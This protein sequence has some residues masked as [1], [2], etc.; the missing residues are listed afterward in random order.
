MYDVKYIIYDFLIISLMK[1]GFITKVKLS[2]KKVV[3]YCLP[4]KIVQS[5]SF[6]LLVLCIRCMK[7]NAQNYAA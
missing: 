4:D 1:V 3:L 7:L 2:L 5:K 6:V